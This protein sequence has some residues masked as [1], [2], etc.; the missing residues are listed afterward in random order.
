MAIR[1]FLPV[2]AVPAAAA[3]LLGGVPVAAGAATA[4][5]AGAASTPL[6]G[7]LTP[8]LA[9]QLAQHVND[10]VIVVLK[11]Q[12][13]TASAGSTAAA[14]RAASVQANQAGLLSE[15]SQVHAVHVQQYTL[16]NSVAATV[17]A[18]EAQ[19]LAANP[20]V[21]AVI[22]DAT[23]QMPAPEV[24]TPTSPSRTT[25][26][27]LHNI[28]GACAPN[29][30]SSLAP[31]GLALT[32]TASS[33]VKQP[34][35]RSLGI[36]GAG[37][38]VAF[39]ADGV[40]TGNVNFLRGNGK[41]VFVDYR[42]F[43]GAGQTAPTFGGE[44]FLDA[45]T[46]A[47]QG[48]HV[49]NVN[50]FTAQ[51]YAT[52]CNV[53][54][55]GVAPGASLVGLDIFSGD[56][57]HPYITTN[58]VIAEAINYA[59]QTDHVNVI[60]ESFGSNPFP[61]STVDVIRLF[62]DAA[63]AAGVVVSVST[64]DSGTTSTIG[65]PSTDP[66]VISVGASTQFQAYAQANLGVA[67]YFATKGWLSDNISSLS[68]AGF[69]QA[70]T[71][72][73]LVAPGDLSWASCSTNV[74][75]YSDC[76]N[77][78]G[79]PTP[80][81]SAGGTSESAPFVSGAAALVIQA[82]RKTH[83]GAT[84]TPALVKQILLS[85][86]TDLGIPAQEQGA[87]LLNSYKAVQLAESVGKS[88]RTGQ[89]LLLSAN[90]LSYTGLPGSR[91]SWQITVTNN[92][93]RP[94][95]VKVGGRALGADANVQHGNVTLN[96][97]TSNQLTY[98]SG[99]KENYSVFHFTV[100][101]G[102]ARLSASLAW[103]A[104][105]SRVSAPL[106]M[107]LIDPAGRLAAY[108]LPQGL[109]NYGN[110]DVRLPQAGTWTGIIFGL[111]GSGGGFTGTAHW[112]VATEK[113]AR[114]GWLS[115]TSFTLAPGASKTFTA[116][117]TAPAAAGDSAGAFVV[118]SNLST[119]ISIPVVVRSMVNLA[120]GGAFSG[121]LTGGNGRPPGLAQAD[122]YSFTVPATGVRNLAVNLGIGG[123]PTTQVGAYLVSPDGNV[124]GYGMN[125]ALSGIPSTKLSAFAANP[126]PGTWTVIVTFANQ[127]V[128]N[129]VSEGFIGHVNFNRASVS[130]PKLPNTLATV[131]PTAGLTVPVTIKN[132]SNAT[133][134]YYFD[135]R[136][137]T[138][139]PM[140]L[141]MLNG[142]GSVQLPMQQN[143]GE[144]EYF[145][146][147]E[148]SSVAVAQ[149]STVPAM[150]DFSPAAGD[151]AVASAT[152]KPTSLCGASAALSVTAPGGKL[153]S[154]IWL[155][156]PTECGPFKSAAPVGEANDTVTVQAAPFDSA[157]NVS[158]TGDL[159]QLAVNPAAA[160]TDTFVPIELV[161]GQSAVVNVVVSPSAATGTNAGI[162][163]VDAVEPG[164]P[165]YGQLAGD[166]VAALP[167]SY[168]NG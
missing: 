155:L 132:T 70:A 162:L 6:S 51:S 102:Q 33:N 95:A 66:N 164:V 18:A 157:V 167:Y 60:N 138:P 128:G 101:A 27:P 22:P 130:A 129:E 75:Q 72:L 20:A 64:G 30:A 24:Q 105:P 43:S 69:T 140:V 41:S 9:A 168:T 4:G 11:S 40:A 99:A 110:V 44:A 145:M 39:I 109:G 61:D 86:A 65:S 73:N 144:P 154:G 125:M 31:E 135:A 108:T 35:A 42:D 100:P 115:A 90:Q 55:Q 81:E 117:V 89:T 114:F 91:H 152:S 78:V 143:V 50:G 131:V 137:A 74:A 59:V 126:K 134:D 111:V 153:T 36:N 151:P 47:G 83:A 112:Q 32:G 156:A 28:P 77:D 158:V 122:Y 165:P 119:P 106:H 161:P 12:F 85:T 160:N 148:A 3:A 57:S 149:T 54:I 127:I 133:Q 7:P 142:A 84:P 8:A 62:D 34:T 16:V 139:G 136:G 5:P 2:L 53:K 48:L 38:K 141:T 87:G 124:Q 93:W 88:G 23:V 120:T 104:D 163:Y 92:G 19:R 52:P 97:K 71:T 166:E 46:I 147:S 80:I 96:D 94:Q 26:L 121:V 67:R 118:S 1:R 45:N 76:T 29:G 82:Y 159:E 103:P 14:A 56:Q 79:N 15:L 21:K 58:S 113:Y 107:T 116:Q 98:T 68:S 17:S 63:V 25:T 10:P 150:V 123:N 37:V 13:G 146:P 49:Y